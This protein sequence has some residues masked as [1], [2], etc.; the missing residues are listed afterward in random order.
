MAFE[1][2]VRVA[3]RNDRKRRLEEQQLAPCAKKQKPASQ[4]V[5]QQSS[6]DDF[7]LRDIRFLRCLNGTCTDRLRHVRAKHQRI[8]LSQGAAA[9]EA[10]LISAKRHCR[11]SACS[12]VRC[13]ATIHVMLRLQNAPGCRIYKGTVRK[14]MYYGKHAHVEF[15][16]GEI[17]RLA[18]CKN[19]WF[20]TPSRGAP[21]HSCPMHSDEVQ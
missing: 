7:C 10:F 18:L 11:S 19:W 8:Q 1:A 3:A 9:A 13:G 5:L 16:D 15:E 2:K 20:H 14:L 4:G 21:R 17:L 6:I 12:P